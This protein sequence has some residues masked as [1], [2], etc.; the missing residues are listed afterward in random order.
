MKCTDVHG[1]VT[2]WKKNWYSRPKTAQTAENIKCI[3]NK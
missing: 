3:S 1:L 2:K